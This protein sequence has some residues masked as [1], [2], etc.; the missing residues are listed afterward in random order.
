MKYFVIFIITLFLSSFVYAQEECDGEFEVTIH[1]GGQFGLCWK[2]SERADAYRY[3]VNQSLVPDDVGWEIMPFLHSDCNDWICEI[4]RLSVPENT[5]IYYYKILT[6]SASVLLYG[7]SNNA[8]LNVDINM[9]PDSP[10]N[11]FAK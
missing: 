8:I 11:F 6:Y 10:M 3:G 7:P 5:G 4:E 2:K 1:K 9:A